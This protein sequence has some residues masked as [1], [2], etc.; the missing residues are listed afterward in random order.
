MIHDDMPCSRAQATENVK[1][2]ILLAPGARQALPITVVG[3]GQDR[4]QLN[5]TAERCARYGA[6]IQGPSCPTAILP[7]R[8]VCEQLGRGILA[9]E[10]GGPPEANGAGDTDHAARL[11]GPA[12]TA[13]SAPRGG[14][15][16]T[17]ARPSAATNGPDAEFLFFLSASIRVIRGIT[18]LYSG[19]TLFRISHGSRK[20][21]RR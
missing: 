19:T 5:P 12:R 15:K 10:V 7:G 14:A 3:S 2:S 13:A 8:M 21:D 16:E 11:A 1:V 4:N 20:M 18:V 6:S 17:T 9:R